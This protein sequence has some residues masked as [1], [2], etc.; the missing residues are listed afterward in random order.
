MYNSRD[1][2]Q[3]GNKLTIRL[4][5]SSSRTVEELKD[6]YYS[7]LR[8]IL[9]ARATS[10]GDVATHP[11]NKVTKQSQLAVATNADAEVTESGVP[12][13]S[14]SPSNVQLP[15]MDVASPIGYYSTLKYE[16][17]LVCCWG[18]C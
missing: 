10:S 15:P 3:R 13:E 7:V 11:L 9:L 16:A 6:W 12:G 2:D 5:F 14:L 17:L 1:V 4:A 18:G 8:A